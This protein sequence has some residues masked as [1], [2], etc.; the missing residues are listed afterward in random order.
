MTMAFL[1]LV[2]VQFVKAFVFRSDRRSLLHRPFANRWLDL[3]VGW[4]VALLLLVVYLPALQR[5]FGT[6]A[7]PPVDWLVVVVAALT[8]APVLELVK[9]LVR[10]GVF[11]RDAPPPGA[12]GLT[13][14]ARRA[15][16]R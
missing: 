9:A 11:G 7:L 10:R 12:L 8:V 1:S 6:F 2:L 14:G 3:A 13:A 16:P 15:R 4:E 5:P